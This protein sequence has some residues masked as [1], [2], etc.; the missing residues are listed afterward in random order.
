[1][2]VTDCVEII[3]PPI[4]EIFRSSSLHSS[5]SA[6]RDIVGEA[7]KR[8]Q[9]VVACAYLNEEALQAIV[10]LSAVGIKKAPLQHVQ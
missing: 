9:A 7:V 3:S 10:S 5:T 1:V 2:G 6:Q 8:V 4:I